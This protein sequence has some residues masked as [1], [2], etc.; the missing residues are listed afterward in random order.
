M[1]RYWFHADAADGERHSASTAAS[2]RSAMSNGDAPCASWC[3]RRSASERGAR[4]N[5]KSGTVDE[6]GR[7]LISER[8]ADDD[9][10]PIGSQVCYLQAGTGRQP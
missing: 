5:R 9:A 2:H 1:T 4:L 8:V 3:A 6:D 7:R 10:E